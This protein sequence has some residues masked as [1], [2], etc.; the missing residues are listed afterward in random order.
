MLAIDDVGVEMRIGTIA[1]IGAFSRPRGD[2]V[3]AGRHDVF[4]DNPFAAA[5][6]AR[7]C[8]AL[9]LGKRASHGGAMRLGKSRVAVNQRLDA[10]RLG[11]VEG[12]VP[13]GAAFA[14]AVGVCGL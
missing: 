3:E 8:V 9:K 11:R 14:A 12:R 13:S 7:E 1:V 2:M 6:L 10:D 5:A 4:G